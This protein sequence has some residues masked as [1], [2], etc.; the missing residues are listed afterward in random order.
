M[1]F[2]F[3]SQIFAVYIRTDAFR[4]IL[5]ISNHIIQNRSSFY[6]TEK[7]CIRD[8]KKGSLLSV[9][10]ETKTAMGART[11]RKWVEQPLLSAA[12]ICKRLDAVEAVSYT[13][14]NGGFSDGEQPCRRRYGHQRSCRTDYD[15][16]DYGWQSERGTAF[17]PD[18]LAPLHPASNFV[19]YFF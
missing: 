18:S 5:F 10:D 7:M 1:T 6:T 16:A 3:H 19:S 12:E 8:S 11:L 13:H 2:A 4:G 15:M 17:V 14:L 9:L